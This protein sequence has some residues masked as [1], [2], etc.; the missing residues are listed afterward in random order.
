M[1]MFYGQ[2]T[3]ETRQAF[4]ESLTLIKTIF[5]RVYAQDNLIALQ[6]T[7]GFQEDER[8]QQILQSVARNQQERSLAWRLHTLIWAAQHCLRVEGDWVE[9][10]V[11]RGFSFAVVSAYVNFATVAKTL[12]LYDTYGGIP[13]AYNSENRSNQV[14]ERET[15]EDPDA[16]YKDV[17][18]RFQAYP[19]VKLVRGIVPNTFT[20]ACPES[21]AFLHIDMNSAASELA[22]LNALFERVSPGGM[23]VFDD[24][25][26]SGYIQQKIAE[27]KFM[28]QRG[29]TI[30]ELPTGQGLVVKQLHY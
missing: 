15:A 9:C 26:W 27:D 25:G 21:I 19:N 14:Y 12:Y 23:I 8:F 13:E 24:Y 4:Q 11:Y 1:Y 16:I 29:Y 5:G 3:Q 28:T 2:F 18:Q 7:A 30:L 17:Q 20:E 10:G 6:R 22:V